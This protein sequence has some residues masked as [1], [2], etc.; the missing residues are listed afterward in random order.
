MTSMSEMRSLAT[1]RDFARGAHGRNHEGHGPFTTEQLDTLLV[2]ALMVFDP[3]TMYRRVNLIQGNI[4][5]Q[6]FTIGYNGP[7]GAV[8]VRR[9]SQ[10]GEIITTIGRHTS[11]EMIRE[12]FEALKEPDACRYHPNR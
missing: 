11:P 8:T 5:G 10:V 9:G 2:Q 1:F 3:G 6:Q 12:I 4:D 7:L